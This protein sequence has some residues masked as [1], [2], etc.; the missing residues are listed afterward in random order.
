MSATTSTIPGWIPVTDRLPGIDVPCLAYCGRD[1]GGVPIYF[2]ATYREW[3]WWTEELDPLELEV[4][5]WMSM[6]P[7]PTEATPDA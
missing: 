6:P 3:M 7:A 4:T 1:V 2:F 5:H